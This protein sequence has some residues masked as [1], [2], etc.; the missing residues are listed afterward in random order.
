VQE[1]MTAFEHIRPRLKLSLSGSR[2]RK[3]VVAGAPP[4]A[5]EPVAAPHEG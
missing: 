5:A 1:V 4:P 3:P 2:L